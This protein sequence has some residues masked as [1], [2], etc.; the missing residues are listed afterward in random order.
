MGA[1][2]RWIAL[3]LLWP[4]MAQAAGLTAWPSQAAPVRN[5]VPASLMVLK[6]QST[7][8]LYVMEVDQTNGAFP[9]EGVGG[10]PVAVTATQGTTPWIVAGG[11]T[12]GSPAAGVVTVQGNA[13]GTPIPISGSI[14]A[15]NAA[16]GVIGAAAPTSASYGGLLNGSNLI[17]ALGDSSGRTVIA[18]AGTA[19]SAAG[20]V[21]T[22]Q[23]SAS[24]TGVPV[25]GTFWQAT[26]PISGTVTANAGTG[27]FT[28]SGTVT[29]NA[30]TGTFTTDQTTAAG[31][32][33]DGSIAFGS[34]T[35]SYQTVVT[36]GGAAKI[37]SMRNNSNAVIVVSLNAG[38]TTSYT[39]DPSDAVSLDLKQAGLNIASST[40]LSAKYSGSAPTTGSIRINV[41]Y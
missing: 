37:V 31:T 28:V 13:S 12:A 21:L 4:T 24:G 32:F 19:G 16:V 25:T 9:V 26:Q 14:T 34:L 22:I 7:N 18:G 36:T 17:G 35:T 30:G 39:L 10:A 5:T 2:S 41:A 6:G 3:L 38:S 8:S 20:G 27:T 11:G 23:G 1:K 15:T 33:Q 40:A 29:A